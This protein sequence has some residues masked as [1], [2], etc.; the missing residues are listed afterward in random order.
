VTFSPMGVGPTIGYIQIFDSAPEGGQAVNLTGRGVPQAT[1]PGT[2]AIQATASY[3]VSY[4][5]NDTHVINIPIN[6]Q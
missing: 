1:P 6:V 5:P 2:Y 3:S 4:Y